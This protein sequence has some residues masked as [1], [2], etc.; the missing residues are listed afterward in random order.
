LNQHWN[1]IQDDILYAANALDPQL[2]GQCLNMNVFSTAN[3]LIQNI[4]GNTVKIKQVQTVFGQNLENLID[5]D[6]NS[7]DSEF[8]RFRTNQYPY[9]EV[10]AETEDPVQYWQRNS[11]NWFLFVNRPALRGEN[12]LR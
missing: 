10:S 5:V 8:I 7:L 1:L 12:M 6:S 3:K 4:L 2:R 11:G 9:N